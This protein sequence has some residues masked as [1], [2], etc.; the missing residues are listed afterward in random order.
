MLITGLCLLGVVSFL[1]L[2][3]ELFPNTELPQLVIYISGPQNADPAY[4]EH[5]AVIPL[6]GAIAGLENIEKIESFVSR[7]QAIIFVYY[8]KSSRQK[9]DYLKLQDRVAAASAQLGES[10]QAI[11]VRTDPEQISNQ[12]LS[13]QARGGG[14]LDQIR[15]FIDEKVTPQLETIDG[16]ANVNV[17]GGH[18]RC[19]EIVRWLNILL[20]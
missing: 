18:K 12:F 19:I 7:R 5:Y 10:F 9:Y 17:Y 15:S 1:Q 3:F 20:H 6:E 11:V 4:V 2:P 13:F 8:N 14:S 16:V